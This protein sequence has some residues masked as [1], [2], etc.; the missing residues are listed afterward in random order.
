M[1]NWIPYPLTLTGET[2]ELIS[3]EKNHFAELDTL[4]KDKRIWEFSLS[5]NTDS[6]VMLEVLNLALIEREDGNQYPFAI[7]H[8]QHKKLIGSTR[9]LEIE[10]K[11]RKLEIGATWLH[12]TYWATEV[13]LEC[14]LLLLTYCFE[15]LKTARVQLRA[16]E[17][18]VR[19]RKAIAKIGAQFEGILR[20]DLIRDNGTNRNSAYFGMIDKEWSEKKQKLTDLY[21]AK[22]KLTL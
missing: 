1:A 19:S 10:P 7:F 4:A 21:N 9:F 18:N 5:D 22:K 17:N 15:T 11:H 13:N 16:D 3:L 2:V 20:N 14:K 8:K 6:V 12:P